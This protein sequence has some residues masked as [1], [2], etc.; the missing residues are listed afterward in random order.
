ML[1]ACSRHNGNKTSFDSLFRLGSLL[2]HIQFVSPQQPKFSFFLLFFLFFFPHP[3]LKSTKIR[4]EPL[5]CRGAGK[6]P[7][8]MAHVKP[9]LPPT[10]LLLGPAPPSP[11]PTTS[12][13]Q[14]A[15]APRY[16]AI[17]GFSRSP[18]PAG[19]RSS[20][21][22]FCPSQE[23]IML[24]GA[25]FFATARC[26]RNYNHGHKCMCVLKYTQTCTPFAK[27]R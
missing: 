4:R 16:E 26:A 2:C 25:V 20:T 5:S 13:S 1:R 15:G 7:R 11:T 19:R 9:W 17:S 22:Y 14:G 12:P 27:S 24:H 23:S 10:S 6:Q 21:S 3:P 8:A 18:S